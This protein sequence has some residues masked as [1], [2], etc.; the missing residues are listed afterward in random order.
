MYKIGYDNPEHYR[1]DEYLRAVDRWLGLFLIATIYFGLGLPW[2]SNLK[3]AIPGMIVAYFLTFLL[4]WLSVIFFM[5]IVTAVK[6]IYSVAKDC[7]WGVINFFSG[8]PL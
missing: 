3:S 1:H 5:N 2:L 7:A 8:K 4:T 6:V